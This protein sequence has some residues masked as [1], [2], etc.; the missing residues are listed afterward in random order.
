MMAGNVEGSISEPEIILN[1]IPSFL[2]IKL[3]LIGD[4]EVNIFITDSNYQY[5]VSFPT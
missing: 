1:R 2:R 3:V 4:V 5:N